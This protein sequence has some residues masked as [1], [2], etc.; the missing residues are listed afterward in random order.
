MFYEFKWIKNQNNED[1][2]VIELIILKVVLFEYSPMISKLL[3]FLSQ[4]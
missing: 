2:N 3:R 4:Q 1:I